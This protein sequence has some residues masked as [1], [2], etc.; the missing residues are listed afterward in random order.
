M[1]KY[2]G[3]YANIGNNEG[4]QLGDEWYTFCI[5]AHAMHND[6]YLI[7]RTRLIFEFANIIISSNSQ[8]IIDSKVILYV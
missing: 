4:K 5:F 6:V 2:Y 3:I 1:G 7:E 8:K